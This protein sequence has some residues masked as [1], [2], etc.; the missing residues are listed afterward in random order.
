MNKYFLKSK[1]RFLS[2]LSAGLAGFGLAV[3]NRVLGIVCLVL[4]VAL[5]YAYYCISFSL[6]RNNS[7]D[8]GVSR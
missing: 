1:A 8:R 7:S 4:A 3:G 2:L 5:D 6:R